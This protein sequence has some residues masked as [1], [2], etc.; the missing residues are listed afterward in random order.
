MNDFSRYF[1]L[2]EL[3]RSETAIRMDI[4]NTPNDDQA[5]CLWALANA[6]LD[7]I[8]ERWGILHISSGFRC[9]QLNR[10]IGGARTSQH[11]RGEAADVIPQQASLAGVFEWIVMESGLDY[12]QVIL[13][14]GWIH[15]SYTS[16]QPNRR[17]ALIKD[18]MESPYREYV[19]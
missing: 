2:P 4:D 10:A 16:R 3:I 7:P 14:P 17:Q 5:N 15:I 13:E 6:I 9:A 18:T 12:D 19:P 11:M 8:R 1:S